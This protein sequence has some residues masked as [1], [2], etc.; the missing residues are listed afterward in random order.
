M[1]KNKKFQT[2]KLF[3]SFVT[4]LFLATTLL[5]A[6]E[7]KFN[8]TIQSNP[9]DL[10]YWW[11]EKNNFGIESNNFHFQTNWE[12]N[13]LNTQYIIN[14]FSQKEGTNIYFSESFIKHNFS[15]ETFLKVGKYYRDFSNYLNDELSSG[16]M[17]ISHNA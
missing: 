6:R 2:N 16:S 5:L 15:E 4:M 12:L 14:T 8:L 1:L 11:L 10:D 7:Q 13:T 17:L 9:T 3:I